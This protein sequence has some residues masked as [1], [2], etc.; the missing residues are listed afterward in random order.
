MNVGRVVTGGFALIML[1]TFASNGE[2]FG[3]GFDWATK[4][5]KRIGD[6]KV[7]LIPDFSNKSTTQKT[8]ATTDNGRYTGVLIPPSTGLGPGVKA[9]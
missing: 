3:Q 4:A 7:A 2:R 1:Y 5:V 8:T 9:K 6:P